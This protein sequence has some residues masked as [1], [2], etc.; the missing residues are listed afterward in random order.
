[1]ALSSFKEKPI[2]PLVTTKVLVCGR[3]D[4]SIG[5][6][7]ENYGLPKSENRVKN[8]DLLQNGT[9]NLHDVISPR[10]LAKVSTETTTKSKR[11]HPIVA[12]TLENTKA[13]WSQIDRRM[14]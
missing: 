9:A 3:N 1:M 11:L 10:L 14:I 13:H 6:I 5:L 8:L 7:I 2:S 4:S 12:I